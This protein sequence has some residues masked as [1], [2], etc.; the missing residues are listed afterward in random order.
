MICFIPGKKIVGDL[1][2]KQIQFMHSPLNLLMFS[3]QK[4]VL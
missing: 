3:S 2:V 1:E 4:G